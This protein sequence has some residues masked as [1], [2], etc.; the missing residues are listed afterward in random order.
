MSQ[1]QEKTPEVWS[2]EGRFQHLLHS[3]RG[4]VEGAMIDVEGIPVQFVFDKHAHDCGTRA[5]QALA[6]GQA[7]VAEGTLVPPPPK[8]EAP[9]EVFAFE[10]LVSIDGTAFTPDAA[11]REVQGTVARI[12]HARHGE[13]NGVVL[14]TGDFIHTRPDGFAQ[15]GAGLELGARVSASGPARPL[16]GGATGHVIEART[17]NGQPLS[18]KPAR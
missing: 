5:F 2:L 15:L 8:G 3:P 16:Q 6:A 7:V 17:V 11:E 4:E 10:R 1:P 9:H 12:H 18:S 13:P 14:D